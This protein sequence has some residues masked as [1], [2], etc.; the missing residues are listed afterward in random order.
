MN[1][2]NETAMT[3]RAFLGSSAKLSAALAIAGPI[4][5]I[6]CEQGNTVFDTLIKNGT[7]FDG[8]ASKPYLADIGIKG[9]KIIS[10]GKLDGSSTQVIDATGL[11]VTPGFIDIHTH[12]DLTFQR[13]GIKRYLAYVMPSFKGNHNYMYQGVSTVVTGNCG[14][15]YTDTAFWLDLVDTMT[16]GSNVLH[17]A[18]HG[19]IRKELFGDNQPT[20]LST[21]Q[22]DAMKTRVAE[23]MEK[24][25]VGFSTGLEYAPGL[26][27]ST[28]ELIEINKVV[29]QYGGLH[30][31]HIRDLTGKIMAN[32][33]FGIVQALQEA[34]EI[35][36]RAEISTQISH[37]TLKAPYNGVSSG[38]LFDVIEQAQLD[39]MDILA[40]QFPYTAGATLLSARLPAE[41]KSD[42]GIKDQY[43]T[44]EGRLLV[45]KA[46]EERFLFSG[47]EQILIAMY[48]ENESFEGR[49]LNEI[50]QEK[51][52]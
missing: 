23:E 13:T 8:T 6:G 20:E 46:I 19:M 25:A 38:Q 35:G 12:C 50:A 28:R 27:A 34:V 17:L 47:P 39:G 37:L 48:P 41:F 2:N 29:S 21:K 42:A 43:K 26:Q 1:P 31:T 9:D 49:T 51:G 16:F 10:I 18:P 7:I 44:K 14:Y 22:L 4:S 33:G 3:R 24:G 11:T 36:K 40:D 52:K 5:F 32:G 45:K 30:T 15:G